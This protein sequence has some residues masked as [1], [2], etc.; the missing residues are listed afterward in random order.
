VR[1]LTIGVFTHQLT[2][3][4]MVAM[5][6]HLDDQSSAAREFAGKAIQT[7][8]ERYTNAASLN[9]DTGPG[10]CAVFVAGDFNSQAGEEAYQ[11]MTA[12]GSETYD[13]RTKVREHARYGHENTFTGFGHDTPTRI[14]FL[15]LNKAQG[16][17]SVA[18]YTVLE[19]RFE[20]GVYN[21]D[22]RAVVG[23]VFLR[24]SN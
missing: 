7:Q 11:I 19:N 21:S 13:L 23:D 12:A 22:H 14:D 1:I 2:G 10:G 6:T 24:V 4:R 8:V 18:G 9:S 16:H 17:W 15:F 3:K 5:N 20:D